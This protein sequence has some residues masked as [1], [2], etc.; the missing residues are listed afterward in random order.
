MVDDAAWNRQVTHWVATVADVWRGP[1]A[2]NAGQRMPRPAFVPVT[3]HPPLELPLL[4]VE[5]SV[6]TMLGVATVHLPNKPSPAAWPGDVSPLYVYS[7]C[8]SYDT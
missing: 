2:T 5:D 6:E 1:L 8:P 3:Y 7:R 4:L